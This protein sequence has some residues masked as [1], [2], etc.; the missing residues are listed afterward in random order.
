VADTELDKRLEPL[1][2][3]PPEEFVAARDALARELREAGER[4]AAAK[5][6]K[7]RRPSQSAWLINRVAIDEPE[8]ARELADAATDLIAAQ[9]KMLD[10]GGDAS[11]LRT[12]A[13]AERKRV[14]R[15]VEAA[16]QVAAHHRKPIS[17]E[18]IERV[19]Q[20]LQAIGSDPELRERL[21]RGRVERD[22]RAATIGLPDSAALAARPRPRKRAESRQVKRARDELVRLREELAASEELRDSQRHAVD[23]AEAEARRLKL[24]LGKSEAEAR[25]LERRIAAAERK[26]GG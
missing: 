7:L 20:T 4:E 26:L 6:K 23:E 3:E 17:A 5:V 2:R 1:Y 9:Q 19:G 16:R 11:D 18:V 22:H 14:Q 21:V 13:D 10:E 12:A 15:M 24:E 25:E 8:R